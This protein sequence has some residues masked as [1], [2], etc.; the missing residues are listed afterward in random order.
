M[1][2]T[3]FVVAMVSMSMSDVRADK[4][5]SEADAAKIRAA[6]LQEW[7]CTGGKMEQETGASGL[8]EVDDAKCKGLQYDIKL[9]EDFKV[10]LISSD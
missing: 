9:D 2:R 4:P 8:Y 6:T 1:M 5:V 7:G 10:I 3:V